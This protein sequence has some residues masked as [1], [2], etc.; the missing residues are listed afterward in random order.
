M[1]DHLRGTVTRDQ[2]GFR[3]PQWRR[4]GWAVTAA[5]LIV[6]VVAVAVGRAG[7]GQ[8]PVFSAYSLAPS[9]GTLFGAWVQPWAY[10]GA[11]AEQSAILG[12]EHTIGRK[13]A[14]DSLY[15]PWTGQMPVSAAR[16]VLRQ[17]SIPMISWAAAPTDEIAA[18]RY[19]AQIIA[20]ARQLKSL[21]GPV[22]LRWFAEMNLR[23]SLPDAISPASYIAAWR[24]IHQIFVRV[25]ASN[26]RWVW[27]PD[28]SGFGNAAAAASYYPGRAYVDWIGADGYNWGG[29][30]GQVG[31][32]SFRQIF[33]PFYQW[34]L[35]TGKPM[36]VGEFGTVEGP[37]GAK[38]A[39]FL[40]AARAIQTEFPAIRAVLYFESDHENFGQN[41]DWR[42]T[43][44]ES[45]L[46][47][48]R[49]FC[50]DSY[51]DARPS[52][53]SSNSRRPAA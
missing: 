5:A 7:R 23:G 26:V 30:G 17:G 50:N 2:A 24:H 41:F 37:Q 31:W 16:W 47:A 10:S 14:I 19:D 20:A 35:S 13:L 51:F 9:Y 34:G 43:T 36:L 1:G 42:V 32:R 44:S 12:F 48:F 18:G 8:P 45:A 4:P 21:H 28:A 29:E 40:Q 27:C 15:V 52:D 33:L 53:L 39:W 49:A 22:L 3:R 25:G 46:A 38:A 11:D 6:I